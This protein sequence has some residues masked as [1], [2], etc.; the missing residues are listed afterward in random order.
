VSGLSAETLGWPGG[1]ADDDLAAE[2]EAAKMEVE[3]EQRQA[4]EPDPP[5]RSEY[6]YELEWQRIV[7]NAIVYPVLEECL[8]E[9]VKGETMATEFLRRCEEEAREQAEKDKLLAAEAEDARNT[10]LAELAAA[11]AEQDK[12]LAAKAAQVEE[13]KTADAAWQ[14]GDDLM[15]TDGEELP[16]KH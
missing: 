14:A 12:E 4:P 10:S 7:W 13:D 2:L 16:D 8:I 3:E 5:W 11:K 9:A 6:P 15:D 1:A